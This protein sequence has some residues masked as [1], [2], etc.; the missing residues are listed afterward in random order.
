MKDARDLAERVADLAREEEMAAD[1]RWQALAAGTISEADRAELLALAERSP[2]AR[3]AYEIFQ[4]FGPDLT[5]EIVDR[6]G[7]KIAAVKGNSRAP[8]APSGSPE[9]VPI[10]PRRAPWSTGLLLAACFAAIAGASYLVLLPSAPERIAAYTKDVRGERAQRGTSRD[11]DAPVRLGPGA[12]FEMKL[13]PARPVNG[14][15][16]VAAALRSGGSLRRWEPPVVISP[17]GV[18]TIKG[19]REALFAG[20]P[21]GEWELLVALGRPSALPATP[22]ALAAAATP[23]ALTATKA[24]DQPRVL[25]V[26]L[27]PLSLYD[28][29]SRLDPSAREQPRLAR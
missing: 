16:G 19:P 18:V 11:E 17:D 26:F 13:S 9:V 28:K 3:R 22:E 14:S 7:P 10:R 5:D 21:A 29:H 4:P 15:I 24:G 25:H 20:V 27:V 2:E 1:P 23:E 12:P 8:P 6:L